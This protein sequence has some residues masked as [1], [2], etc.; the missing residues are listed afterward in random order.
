M[1]SNSSDL[2]SAVNEI[3]ELLRLI[4]EPQIAARDQKLRDELSR[5]VGKSSSK[6]KAVLL[7]DGKHTQTELVKK[8]GMQ[9]GNMSVLVKTLSKANL[10]IGDIKQPQLSIS[11]PP[12]FFDT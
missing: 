10:L 3:R 5:Q 9:K 7:M 2:E 4:A 8:S 11:I 6:A 12:T 1:N